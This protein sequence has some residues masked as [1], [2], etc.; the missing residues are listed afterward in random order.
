MM[1]SYPEYSKAYEMRE[2]SS[3]W[4]Q[5]TIASVWGEQ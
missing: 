4:I 5:D 2:A 1:L 3:E